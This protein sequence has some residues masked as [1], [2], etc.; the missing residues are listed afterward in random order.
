MG[1]ALWAFLRAAALVG[2][3][4]CPQASPLWVAAAHLRQ[5]LSLAAT[6]CGQPLPQASHDLAAGWPWPTALVVYLGHNR[7]PLCRGPWPWSATPI[8]GMA[9]PIEA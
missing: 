1:V 6:P 5:P 4:F 2:G 8:G 3:S 9:A 7:R